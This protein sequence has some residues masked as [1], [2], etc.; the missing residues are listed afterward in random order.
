MSLLA[1]GNRVIVEKPE[2]VNVTKSGIVLPGANNNTLKA[3]GTIISIGKDC[4]FNLNL[5][6]VV[7]FGRYGGLEINHMDKEYVSLPETEILA[8]EG[9]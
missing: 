1:I 6:D 8:V 7:Y 2:T 9:E 3:K 5:G 4:T